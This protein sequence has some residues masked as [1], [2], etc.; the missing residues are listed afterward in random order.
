MYMYSST[1]LCE[2]FSVHI[3]QYVADLQAKFQ[4]TINVYE[5]N[6][7]DLKC[8]SS[9]LESGPYFLEHRHV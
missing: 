5:C 6:Y 7:E 3:K 8:V 1:C 9:I 4:K 2:R